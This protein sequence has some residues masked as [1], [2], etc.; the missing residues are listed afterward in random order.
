MI[1]YQ[2]PCV[3]L[4]TQ[5]ILNYVFIRPVCTALA[6][7]TCA[8]DR[9]GQGQLDLHH[10]YIYLATIT[11]FSQASVYERSA[12]GICFELSVLW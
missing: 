7:I 4:C 5:G 1:P 10:S 12:Q 2:L 9:Y 6:L 3:F 11:N 8:F